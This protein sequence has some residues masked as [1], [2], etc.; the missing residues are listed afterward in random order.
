MGI[1]TAG[2]EALA[3]DPAVIAE[4]AG[5]RQQAGGARILLGVDRLDYTK[6]IPRRLRAFEHLLEQ[7]TGQRRRVRLIQVA[8][9][10]RTGV[11]AYAAFKRQVDELVGR[12]NGRF[13]TSRHVPIHYIYRS[14]SQLQ[15]AAL[16]LAADVMAV[17]PLRDG[18]N[19]VAKEFVCCRSDL[20][21]V[22][23]LSEFAGAATELSEALVI[24][25]YDLEG[26]SAAF[27]Q[28]LGMEPTERAAR[29]QAM[30]ERICAHDVHR[31]IAGFLEDLERGRVSAEPATAGSAEAAL[32]ALSR[33]LRAAERL[34]LFLDYDGTLVPLKPEPGLAAPDPELLVLLERLAARPRT[35]L[36]L[37]SGRDREPLERWF[38]LLPIWLHAEHGLWSRAAGSEWVAQSSAPADW[39][40]KARPILEQFTKNLP[41]SLVEEKSAGLV[42]HYRRADREYGALRAKELRLLLMELLSN[43]PVQVI[44]GDKV[45]ELRPQGVHKGLIVA[46]AL[47][48]AAP[49][50]LA[51]GF[52]DDRT[53]EDLFAALPED[54]VAIRI[55]PGPT[56]AAYRLAGP[57][58]ARAFLARLV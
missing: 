2:F 58:A 3:R 20:D 9:P 16:Y 17:T 51:V 49:D 1:D 52:G 27:A 57:E 24:N 25:P 39:K 18:L 6:G 12:I 13:G 7:E 37:V 50:A 34:V 38:G 36:H 10:S 31:W 53:D 35:S 5:L 22:L 26:L 29:M 14:L 19:L 41:G 32:A 47:A 11:Q 43:V 42:W 4:A 56:R 28:A 40:G 46:Q 54:G 8:V 44:A 23:V 15:L 33:R 48:R 55:G 45:V 21:G 30:R